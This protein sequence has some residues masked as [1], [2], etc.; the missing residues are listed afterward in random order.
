MIKL[1]ATQ[2]LLSEKMTVEKLTH[3]KKMLR[4]VKDRLHHLDHDRQPKTTQRYLKRAV[5]LEQRIHKLQTQR[6]H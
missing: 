4:K 2:R 5:W 6:R 1:Q 3:Y